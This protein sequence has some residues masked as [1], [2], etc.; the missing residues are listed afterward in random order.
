MAVIIFDF[1]GTIADTL[2]AIVAITNRLA[3]K[4]RYPMVTSHDVKQL[5]G[6]STQQIIRHSGLSIFQF[7]RLVRRVRRELNASIESIQPIAQLEPVLRE[8]AHEHRLGIVT[9]N[10]AQNVQRFLVRH[11]LT[12]QFSFIYSGTTLFGKAKVLRRVLRQY[13][14]KPTHVFYVGDE[15]RDVEA[16]KVL[17]INMIAVAWGFNTPEILQAHQPDFLIYSPSELLKLMKSRSRL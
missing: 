9:S 4:Y 7:A 3:T 10:S 17:P 11:Q 14:I 13:Q 6:L 5:Q 8:L 1:D 12:E 15:T 2:D 16:A